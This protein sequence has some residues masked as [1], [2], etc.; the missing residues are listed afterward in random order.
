MAVWDVERL[1]AGFHGGEGAQNHV[2]VDMAHVRDTE[3]VRIG[4]LGGQ[5]H[6]ETNAEGDTSFG[7][8]P[9]S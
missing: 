3:E 9:F 5:G 4:R 1:H 2:G 8:E 6:P 7:F